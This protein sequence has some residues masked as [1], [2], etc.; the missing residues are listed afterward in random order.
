MATVNIS[1]ADLNERPYFDKDSRD[2]AEAENTGNEIRYAEMRTNTIVPLAAVE[3]DGDALRWELEGAD[4]PDFEIVDADDI[5]DG[6]DRVELRFKSQPDFED[7]KG[8]DYV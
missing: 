4:A 3:P 1:I 5:D 6:K 2:R 8:S 7:L